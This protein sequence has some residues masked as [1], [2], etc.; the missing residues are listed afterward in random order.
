MCL[1]IHLMTVPLQSIQY[2]DHTH[3]SAPMLF[4]LKA[5]HNV[6]LMHCWWMC[7]SVVCKM[8]DARRPIP[9]CVRFGFLTVAILA[10]STSWA[11]AATQAFLR[12]KTSG[13]HIVNMLF[14]Y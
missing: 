3:K 13:C 11:D 1:C 2:S 9:Y 5:V 7:G 12:S 14:L 6:S 4:S 8:N 10:Q